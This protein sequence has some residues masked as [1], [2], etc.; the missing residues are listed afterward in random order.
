VILAPCR[1]SGVSVT[2]ALYRLAA[3]RGTGHASTRRAI[4]WASSET[5]AIRSIGP[6][7]AI[8]LC[9]IFVA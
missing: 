3:S 9:G 7:P 8:A 6:S 2:V 4:S 5:G 1:Y